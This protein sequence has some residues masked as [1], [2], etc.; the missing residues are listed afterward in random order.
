[1]QEDLVNAGFERLDP[2]SIDLKPPR[3][4]WGEL[5][6]KF[7]DAEKIEYCEK[8]ASTMNNA[9]YI[10]QGER[11]AL[12]QLCELKEKQ[13]IQLSE[14]I[15]KNNDMVQSEI[16]KMNEERQLFNKHVAVLNKQIKELNKQVK[17]TIG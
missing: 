1:M 6:K 13:I 5:Y 4:K 14:S 7:T 3:I 11:D 15:E 10:I 9:A 17:E 16:M 2:K 12:G 8:L